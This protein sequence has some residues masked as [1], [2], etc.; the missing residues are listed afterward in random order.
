MPG[1][2]HLP[3]EHIQPIRND[4]RDRYGSGFPILKELLQNADDAGVDRRGC[5]TSRIVIVLV[6]EGLPEGQHPLLKGPG[7]CLLNDGDFTAEEANSITSYASSNRGGQVGTAGKFGLGLK[8]IFHWAE[9]FFYFS[10]QSFQPDGETQS[11]PCDLVNPWTSR[12]T[13]QG[14]HRDW[15]DAWEVTRQADVRAFSGIAGEALKSPRWFGLWVPFRTEEAVGEVEPIEKRFPKP[16]FEQLFGVDWQEQTAATIPLLRRVRSVCFGSLRNAQ[17]T[18]ECSLTLADQASRMRFGTATPPSE[19]AP[20]PVK[21]TVKIS[22]A[23]AANGECHFAGLEQLSAVP[24]LEEWRS[25]KFWPARFIQTERGGEKQIPEKAAPHGSVVFTRHP[26]TAD[27][28]LKVQSAVFLPLGEPEQIDCGGHWN[29]RLFLHG[30]FFVDSGRRHIENFDELPEVLPLGDIKSESLIIKLWNRTLLK[31]VVAPLLLPGLKHFIQEQRISAQDTE[32]LI[33][34]LGQSKWFSDFRHWFCADQRYIYRL[35]VTGGSWL[36]EE[37]T[38][39]GRFVGLPKPSFPEAELFKIFPSLED[40]SIRLSVTFDHKPRLSREKPETLSEAD[41]AQLITGASPGIFNELEQLRYLLRLVTREVSNRETGSTLMAA[42]VRLCFGIISS[43]LPGEGELRALWQ[44]FFTGL[45]P[46]AVISLSYD[47]ANAV[48]EI[49]SVLAASGSPVAFL[50]RDFRSEPGAGKIPWAVLLPLLQQLSRLVLRDDLAIKQRSSIAVSLLKVVDGRPQ[51]WLAALGDLPLFAVWDAFGGRMATASYRDLRVRADSNLLFIGGSPL[52]RL[53]CRAAPQISLTFVDAAV[54]DLLRLD[55][56]ICSAECCFDLLANQPAPRLSVEFADRLPLFQELLKAAAGEERK[57]WLALRYLLH[58]EA[59]TSLNDATMFEGSG[60]VA[61]V[62]LAQAALL[63]ANAEWRL[64]PAEVC[65][66]IALT[67][68]HRESLRLKRAN[69]VEVT[70]LVLEVGAASVDCSKLSGDQCLRVLQEIL[71]APVLRGLNVHQS[72]EGPRV[73]ATAATYLDSG[74]TDLPAEFRALV[75]LVRRNPVYDLPKTNGP[76]IRVLGW[77]SV[78]EIALAQAEPSQWWNSILTAV[79]QLGN[80][81]SEL[82]SALLDRPWLPSRTSGEPAVAAKQLLHL[83]GVEQE[84]ARLLPTLDPSRLSILSLLPEIYVHPGFTSLAAKVLP[85]PKDVLN[86]LG[87]LLGQHEEF[88]IGLL[89]EWTDELVKDWMTALGATP[90]EVLPVAPLLKLLHNQEALHDLL[91]G[92]FHDINGVAAFTSYAEVLKLLAASHAGTEKDQ[93]QTFERVFARYLAVTENPDRLRQILSVPGVTLL[94]EAGYW[95]PPT[96]LTFVRNGVHEDNIIAEKLEPSLLA[97]RSRHQVLA[98]NVAD[99]RFEWPENLQ[100]L[101]AQTVAALRNYFAPW[102]GLIPSDDAIG[103]FI[104]LLGGPQGLRALAGEFFSSLTLERVQQWLEEHDGSQHAA[105]RT[106]ISNRIFIVQVAQGD[107]LTV[108]SILGPKFEA[109]RSAR[110]TTLFIGGGQDAFEICQ[111]QGRHVYQCRLL[112]LNLGTADYTPNE[113]LDLLRASVEQVLQSALHAEVDITPLWQ[114]LTQASQL[115]IRVAQNLVVDAAQAFLR[116]IGPVRHPPIQEALTQWDE[117]RRREAEEEAHNL[118]TRRADDLRREAKLRLHKLLANDAVTHATVLSAIRGKMSD[119]GYRHDSVPF[120]L[121]QNADDALAQLDQLGIASAPY[122]S[123]GFVV[124]QSPIHIEFIH[125]GRLVNEFRGSGG[126]DRRNEGFDRDLEK[127]LVLSISDKS[128]SGNAGG[129]VLTGKFGLGFKSVFLACDRPEVLSGNVDFTVLAGVYPQALSPENRD[130]LRTTLA[131]AASGHVRRG[132]IIRLNLPSNGAIKSDAILER[133]TRLAP[134]LV[135]FGR[136]LKQ[137]R[138]PGNVGFQWKD[139]PL[140][141]T[142]GIRWGEFQ[143]PIGSAHG[144]LV[145]RAPCG[146][147]KDDASLLL[148]LDALGF[149]VLPE[150]MPVVWATAPTRDTP[151]YGFAINGPFDVDVGRVQLADNP[152]ANLEMARSIGGTVADRL[153]ALWQESHKDWPAVKTRTGLA[154]TLTG[155]E[156]WHSLW[157]LFGPHFVKC[158]SRHV[159][160]SVTRF[161]HEMLWLSESSGYWRFLTECDALPSGLWGDYRR[162]T[163]LSQVRHVATGALDREEVF[164]HTARWPSLSNHVQPGSM[165]SESSVGRALKSLNCLPQSTEPVFLASAVDWQLGPQKL[166][167]PDQAEVLGAL[168]SPA[169]MDA[170]KDGS[171]GTRDVREHEALRKLFDD[172]QFQAQDGSWHHSA[173]LL[174]LR[175]PPV[176]GEPNEESLRAAFAP[177]DCRL[178]SAYVGA[179]LDFF[180][181]CRKRFEADTNLL[182]AWTFSATSDDARIAALRY[183]IEPRAELRTPLAEELRRRLG[184]EHSAGEKTCWLWLVRDLLWW[185]T[186][187]TLQEQNELVKYILRLDD[188][189]EEEPQE[190]PPP[191]ETILENIYN[192]WMTEAD[193]ARLIRKYEA[194]LYPRG[195]RPDFDPDPERLRTDT[196]TRKQWL[197]LWLLGAFHTMGRTRDQQHRN[198]LELCEAQGWL[199]VFANPNSV[200]PDTRSD[201]FLQVLDHYFEDHGQWLPFYHWFRQ[202]VTIYKV[203]RWLPEYVEAYLDVERATESFSILGI[204]N[205]RMLSGFEAPP[206]AQ[207]LGIGGQFVMREMVRSGLIQNPLAFEHCYVPVQRLCRL[208]NRIGCHSGFYRDLCRHLGEERATFGGAFDLPLLFVAEDEGLQRRFLNA[209]LPTLPDGLTPVEEI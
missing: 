6:P 180:L 33:A 96:Q 166:V 117:A 16:D 182:A 17:F 164:C 191:P 103:A 37:G 58:A 118:R 189:I 84:L 201:E 34:S 45:P 197:T 128:E 26:A 206:N 173:V 139:S 116:Q 94:S 28:N 119:Y 14:F 49:A 208:W 186:A 200:N 5:E 106:R 76:I 60:E 115:Q 7:L 198:F 178:H 79:G 24:S 51:D 204:S 92:F 154:L 158:R 18:E 120:E 61:F 190:P 55:V 81:R 209:P 4:L 2:R 163:R 97:L 71:D 87:S 68:P 113:L 188:F 102:R 138:M 90:R 131:E 25:H 22:R 148:P 141:D 105:L 46:E 137:V 64:L 80:P 75:V 10:S 202:F 169:F 114:N 29:Y 145:I 69:A 155:D 62:G 48:P 93:R 167:P 42:L 52:A 54:T 175:A 162:L 152:A 176:P 122:E 8:S 147:G 127:M 15:D 23:Q 89:G 151:G 170:L 160:S 171:D 132:T 203:A 194:R 125:W 91:P 77:D 30:F 3:S 83:V 136:R 95:R 135:I 172:V 161:V 111:E 40:V 1:F 38:D 74:F 44:R 142:D 36:L 98:E 11:P 205:P 124:R 129:P 195:Q 66:Q 168:V 207:G 146:D 86:E 144:A 85:R 104:S 121:W 126:Q 32:L 50:W 110:P 82:Q 107:T 150:H 192:W 65:S 109:R 159:E 41:L 73:R 108:P 99:A 19:S 53:L 123:L 88:R 179:A 57:P 187:F 165:I 156:F 130:S 112:D 39:T 9:A 31:E 78:I 43:R 21:G 174:I 63:A 134:L 181:A 20:Q 133:F 13:R 59:A 35:T 177:R 56:Q 67:D 153:K 47:S 185:H 72:I 70:S 183:L 143:N 140:S 12:T 101:T 157:N 100:R 193:R 184:L 196:E 199:D 27:A 149:S